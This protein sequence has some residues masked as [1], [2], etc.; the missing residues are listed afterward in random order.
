VLRLD[1]AQGVLLR[2]GERVALVPKAYELLRVLAGHAGRIV[3]KGILMGAVWPDVTVDEGNLAKLIFVLRREL[4]NDAIETV[5]RRGYRL[6]LPVATAAPAGSRV[7][8]AAYDLYVEG[9]YL[10]NRRPGD[11]VWKALECFQRA[12][13]LDPSFASAWA[14]IADVYSTLGSWE[15]GVLPHGEAQAKAWSY[16]SRALQLEPRLVDAHTTRAYITLHYAW[17]VPGADA[18]FRAALALDGAYAAAHHWHSHALVAAGRADEALAASQRAL[19]HEPMNLMLHVHL[20]WHWFMTGRADRC[21]EQAERVVSIDPSFHWGHYFLGWGAEGTDEPA[22]AV[23]EM[24]AALAC[25]NGDRV[26]LA[27]LGRA[28]ASAGDHA[29]AAPIVDA[30]ASTDLFDYEL[31]LIHEAIGDHDA[32][33]SALARARAARSGWM[34]YAR[35]DPRL[36][37]LRDRLPGCTPMV[38]L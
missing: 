6:L 10:W 23:D 25:A 27:G 21:L 19:A 5:P 31:A 9:R 28:L 38:L 32:A 4:G 20:A 29:A 36:A 13:A 33:L 2:D 8:A 12:L 37:P 11:V 1:E 14:G 24:R 35:I 7:N 3:P 18:R 26:M 34:V 17:D 22:R 15:S 30:L 16:A